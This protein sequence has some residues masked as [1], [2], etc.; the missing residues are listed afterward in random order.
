MRWHFIAWHA[1]ADITRGWTRKDGEWHI[2]I[3]LVGSLRSIGHGT[4]RRWSRQSYGWYNQSNNVASQVW[5]SLWT[6]SPP[7]PV[8]HSAGRCTASSS[9]YGCPPKDQWQWLT[10]VTRPALVAS[11]LL[12]S[13]PIGRAT[14][15]LKRTEH[16]KRKEAWKG[17]ALW[18]VW[19]RAQ[20]EMIWML[21]R[22]RTRDGDR[23]GHGYNA[24]RPLCFPAVTRQPPS[25]S[26]DDRN[27]NVILT[28]T[29]DVNVFDEKEPS[30]SE[31]RE[32]CKAWEGV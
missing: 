10:T 9:A 23:S 8:W 30:I 3:C 2:W 19:D 32:M 20:R 27:S 12:N 24:N 22:E 16:L 29:N 28:A 25:A 1:K 7:R 4:E 17:Y 11:T 5:L 21:F 13:N 15:V 31:R 26:L 18:E 6:S 14:C